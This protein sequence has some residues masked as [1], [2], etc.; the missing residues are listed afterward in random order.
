LLGRGGVG[1]LDGLRPV[2]TPG[3]L[4]AAIAEVRSVH[5]EAALADYV[6]DLAD[7]TR[8]HPEVRIGASP[9]ASIAL[10]HAA[11]A[12]AVI[13]GR[14]FVAPDDVKAVAVPSLAHR[15]LLAGGPDIHTAATVVRGVLERVP[16]PR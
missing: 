9:R 4:R 1:A 16:V 15:L 10:L 7:A 12:H 5:C 14:G 3:D 8:A 2:T 11:Q 13:A 6:I